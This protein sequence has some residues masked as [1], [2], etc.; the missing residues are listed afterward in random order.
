MTSS[1]HSEGTWA[2]IGTSERCKIFAT[3]QTNLI[4]HASNVSATYTQAD[5]VR[6]SN[7]SQTRW[8]LYLLSFPIQA[9]NTS[10]SH[11]YGVSS[12]PH[13]FRREGFGIAVPSARL[14]R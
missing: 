14:G 1:Q 8:L 4:P 13:P 5:S 3:P 12:A 9:E 7:I 6:V 10:I 2:E 11:F